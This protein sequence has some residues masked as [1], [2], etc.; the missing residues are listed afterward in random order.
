MGG[1]CGANGEIIGLY[2]YGGENWR[3]ETTWDNQA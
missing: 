2:G 1:P 3:K